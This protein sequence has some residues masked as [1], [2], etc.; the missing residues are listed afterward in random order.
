M[1]CT[2]CGGTI[3]VGSSMCPACGQRQGQ[4]ES[5][6]RRSSPSA[7]PPA[8]YPSE[9]PQPVRTGRTGQAGRETAP[10]Q[11][12]RRVSAWP[13]IAGAAVLCIGLALWVLWPGVDQPDAPNG[14]P[15]AETAAPPPSLPASEPDVTASPSGSDPAAQARREWEEARARLDEAFREYTKLATTGGEG[16]IQ[17]ALEIYRQRLKALQEIERKHGMPLTR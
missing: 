2:Q 13:W 16:N 8:P 6:E 14:L 15:P 17:D 4:A 5:P 7:P 3:P 1:F 10:E 12:P 9:V 11:S